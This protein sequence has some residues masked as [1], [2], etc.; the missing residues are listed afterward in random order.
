MGE[1]TSQLR[2]HNP[3]F[4]VPA[5]GFRLQLATMEPINVRKF[6]LEIAADHAVHSIQVSQ[7]K[8][9]L[10][11]SASKLFTRGKK[12]QAKD[13]TQTKQAALLAGRHARNGA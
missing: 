1:P 7:W 12:T 8:K 11:V 13:E 4:K 9:Q 5:K 2:T 3:E 6:R 10:L